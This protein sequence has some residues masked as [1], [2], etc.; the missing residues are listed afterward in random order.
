M[1]IKY[2]LIALFIISSQQL[3]SQTL[4]FGIPDTITN[5]FNLSK[6]IEVVDYNQDGLMDV[7]A[8]NSN[9]NAIDDNIAW[10]ENTG[11]SFT[12]RSVDTDFQ[13]ARDVA[14]GFIDDDSDLDIVSVSRL[15][16][17]IAW[18]DNTGTNT[19]T[20]NTLIDSCVENHTVQL[21]DLNQD[22]YLDI[23]SGMAFEPGLGPDSC[24]FW[25]E[26]S[27]I[28]PGTFTLRVI[29][30]NF[31]KVIALEV[32][33]LDNDN[34]F[35]IA[36]V[37]VG[38]ADENS[39][40]E[41]VWLENDGNEN[42]TQREIDYSA[43]A[44]M[45]V[46]VA[47]VDNDG[48]N[49][50]LISDWGHV[51]GTSHDVVWYENDGLAGSNPAKTWTLRSI[52][53]L[54]LNARTATFYDINGD[55]NLDVVGAACDQ[56]GFGNDGYITYWINDGTPLDGGWSRT[57][58]VDNF[59]YAYH[60]V[61]EDMD[62]DGDLDIIGSSQDLGD[63]LWWEN[64]ISD[65]TT[66][67]TINTDYNLWN[68]KVRVNFDSGPSGTEYLKAFYNA[69]DVPDR[70]LLGTGIDHI[71][72]NGYYTLKTDEP[73][74][75]QD[76]QFSYSGIAEWS[77]VNDES[78]LILCYWDG[79]QWVKASNQSVSAAADS[80]LVRDFSKTDNGSVLW[81]LGSS[82]TDNALPVSLVNFTSFVKND[83]IEL[84]WKTASESENVGFEIWKK[85]DKSTN[86]KLI[87]SYKENTNLQGQGTS[88]IGA[89]YSFSDYDV[90]KGKKYSYKLVDVSYTGSRSEHKE[91]SIYFVPDGITKVDD[92]LPNTLQLSQNYPN[93]F[94]GI[95][96]IDFA[97]PSGNISDIKLI[98][99]N[100]NGQK[101]K[102][103][104]DGNLSEGQY[105]VTWDGKNQKNQV[106]ASGMYIYLLHT[107]NNSII[108]RM[109]L[110]K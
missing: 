94:N 13:G 107:K 90:I 19:W 14:V 51:D 78:D 33:D 103:L 61:A 64:L 41:I 71:A 93:P 97:I 49:D 28:S 69:N 74:Y 87:S 1:K 60:A 11:G 110:I 6:R 79:T 77:V 82:T 57:D 59:D 96:K 58:L 63:I 80:I 68:S 36:L 43:D 48:D 102:T 44:P 35:D 45:F 18:Y 83:G 46:N 4:S 40:D 99:F 73:N 20:K 3:S 76:L 88:S 25:Y 81:T 10:F 100:Q 8:A 17:P 5:S 12:Q 85:T 34:D 37:E 72:T 70:A 65:D 89:D 66:S 23:V 38:L 84:N 50:V 62:D 39:D 52:D 7:V 21:V 27:S 55:G 56:Y 31:Q 29:N 104:Y 42:F 22:G 101:V 95:S 91:I 16:D 53:N 54:F 47:D 108:K 109:T 32:I 98:I 9:S 67:I 24:V 106:V 2:I 86:F 92:L 15:T 75:T 26:N 30:T 105:S